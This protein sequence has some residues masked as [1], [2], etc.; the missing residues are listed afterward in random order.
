MPQ[1]LHCKRRP[2]NERAGTTR[3]RAA[4]GGRTDR[5]I[6][7]LPAFVGVDRM[8]LFDRHTRLVIALILLAMVLGGTWASVTT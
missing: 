5:R 1:L 4:M 6:F 2:R 7:D 8:T 3:K